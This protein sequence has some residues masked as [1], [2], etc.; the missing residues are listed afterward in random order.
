MPCGK[1]AL[2]ET[3]WPCAFEKYCAQTLARLTAPIRPTIGYIY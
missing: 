1:R 2:I 3:L